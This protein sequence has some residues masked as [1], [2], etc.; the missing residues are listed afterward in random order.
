ME[1]NSHSDVTIVVPVTTDCDAPGT[2]CARDGRMLST[3]LGLTVSG[4]DRWTDW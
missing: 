3:W 1:P 2:I 4:L